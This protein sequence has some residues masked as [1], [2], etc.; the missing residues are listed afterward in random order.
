MSDEVLKKAL[1]PFYTSKAT[2]TGLGLPL[3][4][5]IVEAHGGHLRIEQREGGGTEV[6][7][8]VPGDAPG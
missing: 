1:L 5:E 8:W 6:I 4:R 7:C 3:C 2:G